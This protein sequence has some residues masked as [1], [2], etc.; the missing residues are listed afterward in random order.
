MIHD[1]AVTD[2]YVAFPVV[3]ITSNLRWLKEGKSHFQWD[4]T[5]DV[6]IG[7]LPRYGTGDDVRWFRGPTK[8]TT[9]IFNS[10]SEGT[11]L[12]ID[13]P[14]AS[15]NPF[16]FFPDVTGAPFDLMG[17][18]PH[19][20]RWTVDFA[21]SGDGFEAEQL[22][23]SICEFPRIDDRYM[24]HRHRQG[25]VSV[26]DYTKPWTEE[27]APRPFMYFNTIGHFDFETGSMRKWFIGDNADLEEVQFVPRSPDAPEG[28]GYLVAIVNRHAERRS[29]LV[30]LDAQQIEDGP[31]AS[32]ILP[33]KLRSGLHGE[34]LAA[35]TLPVLPLQA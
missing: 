4:P 24:T 33:F 6:Y 34:W 1:F 26:F 29:D 11:R 3:P 32:V 14:V 12:H 8:Y 19:V 7:V 15:T 20:T 5:K 10:F 31:L 17:S 2:E 23:D 18:A 13:T 27:K 9:H 16:P 21:S 28:D 30:V 25:W 35:S 22:D